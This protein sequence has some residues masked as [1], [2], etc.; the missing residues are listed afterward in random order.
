MRTVKA[1]FLAVV[2]AMFGCGCRNIVSLKSG[3]LATLKGS[4]V[5]NLEYSYE[6]LKVG[7]ETEEEYVRHRTEKRDRESG[8]KWLNRWQNNRVARFQPKFEQLLNHQLAARDVDLHFGNHPEAKYTLLLKST[9]ISLGWHIGV[10]YQP[11]F[12]DADAILFETRNRENQ[13]AMVT[14]RKMLGMDPI[15]IAFEQG[16]RVQESY[17]R[18]GKALGV[19]VANTVK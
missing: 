8:D 13:V 17:A 3:S 1:M 4:T 2:C 16:W 12:L 18:T 19:L 11:A 5:V 7:N 6:G 14:F 9:S 15:I 10:M